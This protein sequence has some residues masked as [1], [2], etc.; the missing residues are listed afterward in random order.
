MLPPEALTAEHKNL[1]EKCTFCLSR[2]EKGEKP[3]C[4]VHC[5]GQC[6]VFGDVEDPE[7]EISKYIEAR[8]AKQVEG[9]RIWVVAPAN[10]PEEFL[11]KTPI[12]QAKA[13]ANAK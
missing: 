10:M 9:T 1:V 3:M 12:E 13:K 8:G 4:M 2:V 7:S 6:R 5:P 11:P